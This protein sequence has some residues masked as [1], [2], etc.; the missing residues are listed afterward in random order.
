MIGGFDQFHFLKG[1][2]S[3]QTRREVRRCFEQAGSGGGY[4]LSPWTISSK[5]TCPCWR[6]S[7]PKRG[8]AY[9][10]FR[11]P[12]LFNRRHVAS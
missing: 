11:A 1:C 5:P 8:N 6:R 9:T 3:E 2:T 7:A 10:N 4:I 12:S